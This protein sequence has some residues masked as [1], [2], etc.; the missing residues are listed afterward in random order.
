M[1]IGR[2]KNNTK[3]YDCEEYM[4]DTEIILSLKEDPNF[5][6]HIWDGYVMDIFDA[7]P[8]HGLGWHGFTRDYQEFKGAFSDDNDNKIELTDL[9][10]Y[11]TD[12]LQ[13]E[14]KQFDF[15]A[16]QEVFEL[17]ADFLRYAIATG[18][19]VVMEVS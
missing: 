11:L 8:L 18:Q 15:E 6:L 5:N 7:P 16:T 14:K 9:K 19:T 12:L 3:F 1:D 13:Y 17:I 2:L 4:Y 10:E